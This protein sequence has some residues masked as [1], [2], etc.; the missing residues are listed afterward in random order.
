MTPVYKILS[1]AAW[2]AA[3]AKGRF[4]GAGIDLADGFIHL[5]SEDQWRETLRLHFAGQ[6]GLVLVAFDAASLGEALKWE[7]SRGGRLFPHV[8]GAI[9]TTLA[10][11]VQ[12]I[13][14]S[15]EILA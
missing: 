10:V 14:P 8:Y 7:P 5:S 1:Q 13:G 11:S 4:D 2:T 9:A 12:P 15:G 3:L 6:D